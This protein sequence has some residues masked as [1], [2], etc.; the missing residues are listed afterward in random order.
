MVTI[1][2]WFKF[3]VRIWLRGTG[4]GDSFTLSL[5][6]IFG[7]TATPTCSKVAASLLRIG[8]TSRN[9]TTIHCTDPCADPPVIVTQRHRQSV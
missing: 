3:R 1:R 5:L 8:M 9:P 2:D 6:G 4:L 7:F